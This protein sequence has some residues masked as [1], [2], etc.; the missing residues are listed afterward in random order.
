IAHPV[1]EL[2]D[3]PI[4]QLELI[5]SIARQAMDL[6][7]MLRRDTAIVRSVLLAHIQ[8]TVQF[9]VECARHRG[10]LDDL[11]PHSMAATRR[12]W[13]KGSAVLRS[14]VTI[15][16]TPT[17]QDSFYGDLYRLTAHLDGAAPTEG[18]RRAA[19]LLRER[20]RTAISSHRE[21]PRIDD[22]ANDG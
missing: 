7:R 11:S 22:H 10:L 15:A 16:P 3:E 14:F 13:T 9:L 12:H 6:Y 1:K 8:D 2:A 4:Q 20:A 18:Q 21:L 19:E 17:A 5:P